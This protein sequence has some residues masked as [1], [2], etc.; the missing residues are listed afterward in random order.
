MKMIF[1]A[2]PPEEFLDCRSKEQLLKIGDHYEL[3]VGFKGE[4]KAILKMS[5]FE[6]FI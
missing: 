4:V 6:T 1:F 5:L 3:D 2:S